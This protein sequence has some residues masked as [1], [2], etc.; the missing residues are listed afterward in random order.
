MN[1][2]EPGDEHARYLKAIYHVCNRLRLRVRRALEDGRV[3]LV[4]DKE[5]FHGGKERRHT[6][7]SYQI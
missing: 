4:L 7:R 3:P 2:D 6:A 1:C 5:A